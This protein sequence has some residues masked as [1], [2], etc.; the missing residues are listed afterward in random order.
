M[1]SASVFLLASLFALGGCGSAPEATAQG[2]SALALRTQARQFEA[3]HDALLAPVVFT[4]VDDR[5]AFARV[6]TGEEVLVVWP[7]EFSARLVDGRAELVDS[8]GV[9][10]AHEGDVLDDIGGSGD[11]WNACSIGGQYYR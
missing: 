1:R 8:F 2:P 5:A 10:I 9:V 6:T 4:R 11:P 7:M 3:C